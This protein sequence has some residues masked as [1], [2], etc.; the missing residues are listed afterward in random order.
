MGILYSPPD[1]SDLVKHI[2]N[3]FT[4]T[5]VLHKQECYLLGSLN[6]NLPLTRK[7]F[8]VTKVIEKM[9]KTYRL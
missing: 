8:S 4:E 7:K 2:N 6:I 3:V 9:V 1:K 5:G